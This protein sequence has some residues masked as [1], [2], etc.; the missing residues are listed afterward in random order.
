VLMLS[1]LHVRANM[2]VGLTSQFQRAVFSPKRI[3]PKRLKGLG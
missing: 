3:G 2:A 1:A